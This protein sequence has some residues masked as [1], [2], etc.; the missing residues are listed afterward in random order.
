[1][2]TLTIPI[3]YNSP[4]SFQTSCPCRATSRPGSSDT[5]PASVAALSDR[6]YSLSTRMQ[7]YESEWVLLGSDL[8]QK[9]TGSDP[10][11]KNPGSTWLEN[12]RVFLWFFI[13]K[14]GIL[15]FFWG[16]FFFSLYFININSDKNK[17][18][19]DSYFKSALK[20]S[21]SN[22]GNQQGDFI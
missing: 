15:L 11:K 1:M 17:F 10:R 13:I 12:T 8:R 21:R 14:I 3:S 19:H 20:Y 18:T 9:K 22:L 4:C 16:R 7:G 2:R 5:P 6:K